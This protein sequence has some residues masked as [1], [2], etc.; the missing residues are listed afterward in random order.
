MGSKALKVS[1]L[2]TSIQGEGFFMGLP[3]VFIRLAG[4]NLRCCWCDSKYAW[5]EG[6]EMSVKSII[7]YVKKKMC[8]LVTITG[9]EP[10]LQD[11]TELLDELRKLDRIICVETNGTISPKDS[12]LKN[13]WF[14]VSPKLP[15]S[16]NPTELAPPFDEHE[17]VYYY[18]FVLT[19]VEDFRDVERFVR[20]Y[21]IPWW[22]VVCQPDGTQ[23][24]KLYKQLWKF[25]CKCPYPCRFMPQF[26]RL[27][28]GVRRK[29]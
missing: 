23:G 10:L 18:K 22:K 3:S 8:P 2:F 24:L 7:R 13:V 1:E 17:N 6:R 9:G 5:E 12:Y 14:V 15:S 27:V 29:V 26:H 28:W 16:G 11:L 20:D 19:C 4:C 25:F 21:Q